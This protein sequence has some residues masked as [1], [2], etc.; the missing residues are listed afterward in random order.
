MCL[1]TAAVVGERKHDAPDGLVG[2]DVGR[3]ANETCDTCLAV[4]AEQVVIVDCD[5]T[6]AST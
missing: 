1:G 4:V 3:A 5:V 2:H 6:A